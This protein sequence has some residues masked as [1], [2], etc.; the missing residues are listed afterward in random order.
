MNAEGAVGELHCIFE[1]SLF[2][3]K[4]PLKQWK[5]VFENPK[6]SLPYLFQKYC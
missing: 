4:Q 5:L 6:A 3:R 1:C 2:T